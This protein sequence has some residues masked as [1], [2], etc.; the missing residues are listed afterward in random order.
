M[1]V[2]FVMGVLIHMFVCAYI[3]Q[4][5]VYWSGVLYIGRLVYFSG[6]CILARCLVCWSDCKFAW[7]LYIRRGLLFS[8]GLRVLYIRQGLSGAFDICRVVYLVG[9]LVDRSGVLCIGRA[10]DLLCLGRVPCI[11][12]RVLYIRQGPVYIKSF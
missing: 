5:L 3:G 12:V 11:F 4:G 7:V 9:C 10:S 8:L 1:Y 2:L 6:S